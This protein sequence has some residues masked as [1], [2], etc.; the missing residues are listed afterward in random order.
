MSQPSYRRFLPYFALSLT[1]FTGVVL[2]DDNKLTAQSNT[3]NTEVIVVTGSRQESKLLNFA[4]NVDRI[5]A[6]DIETVSA[7]HPSDILNRATGVHIQ[8]NNG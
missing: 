4:G 7:V 2:A 5:S 1:S 8:T 6:E 3:A